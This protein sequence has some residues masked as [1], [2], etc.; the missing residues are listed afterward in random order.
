MHDFAVFAVRS[1]FDRNTCGKYTHDFKKRNGLV[2]GSRVPI[3]NGV[4]IDAYGILWIVAMSGRTLLTGEKL[5][6]S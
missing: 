4:A 6:F 3:G 2:R 5:D 1:Y